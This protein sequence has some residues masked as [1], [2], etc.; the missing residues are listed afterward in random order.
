MTVATEG[1]ENGWLTWVVALAATIVIVAL[2]GEGGRVPETEEKP[3]PEPVVAVGKD[4]P[5]VD[6]LDPVAAELAATTPVEKPE[7]GY[8]G[9]E[10]CRE[11]HVDEHGT[12]LASYHRTMTQKADPTSVIG[13]FENVTLRHGATN[14]AVR[15]TREPGGYWMEVLSATN[16]PAGRTSRF[17][18]VMTTGSHHMQ[19]CWV[20]IGRGR[21]LANM[22]FVFLKETSEWVPWNSCFLQPPSED[23]SMFPAAWNKGCVNCHTTFGRSRPTDDPVSFDTRAA[24]FGISCE[25]CHGPGADH[26]KYH[27]KGS[28]SNS[29]EPD[30][31]VHPAGIGHQ[32]SSQLCGACHS[33]SVVRSGVPM[34]AFRPGDDLHLMRQV[35]RYDAAALAEI[36]AGAPDPVIAEKAIEK[37]SRMFWPDGMMRVAG[38]EYQGMLKSGCHTH[39]EMSC[40]SCHSM[41]QVKSDPRS[42]KEWAND[43]LDHRRLGD[44]ACTGCHQQERYV[45]S[46]HTH[47][48][49]DSAG[50]RC[51]NCHMP[52]TSYGLLK[53]VRSHTIYNPDV[54]RDHSAGRPNA[55]NLCHLDK[56]LD[57]TA[58]HLSAWYGNAK[59][60]L[61][62]H[63]RETAAGV[64]WAVTGDAGVRALVAWHLGWAPAMNAAGTDWFDPYLALLLDDP[65]DAVRYIAR[66]SMRAQPGRAGFAYE[67]LASS[68]A[69][70]RRRKQMVDDW[71]AT[72]T[73]AGKGDSTR[74]ID[75]A[76]QLDGKRL[77]ALM[78]QRDHRPVFLIE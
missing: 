44:Q 62:K 24:E 76:G 58:R 25:A 12:W 8:V 71:N 2:M 38:R 61:D 34:A 63:E 35:V 9:Q 16:R 30:P 39:G 50:S 45:S 60:K 21:S 14:S 37:M 59:P 77:E 17:P 46:M 20:S 13:N 10:Q 11:C 19:V 66:R 31:I 43:Q 33:Y 48:E 70:S 41:H 5:Q 26:V 18:V 3:S 36:R 56:T 67:F 73:Y 7:H 23:F 54:Q 68:E 32:R 28:D 64:L 4:L 40:L 53:A 51:M 1:T 57:W 69:R 6:A 75:A 27:R 78:Q 74:F 22:P 42:R 15:L 29:V 52:H 65:Y 49:S 55:C 47:H 72:A